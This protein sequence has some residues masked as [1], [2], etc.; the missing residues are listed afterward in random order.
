L[1]LQSLEILSEG[2]IDDLGIGQVV[3]VGL[4]ADRLNPALFDVES[5]ALGL[6]RG[7]GGGLDDS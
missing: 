6:P 1:G 2:F 7:R 5:D 3:E 4:E